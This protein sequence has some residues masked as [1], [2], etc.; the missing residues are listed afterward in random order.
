MNPGGAPRDAF[1][2]STKIVKKWANDKQAWLYQRGPYPTLLVGGQNSG[3]TVGCVLKALTLLQTYPGSR[4]AVIRR[5]NIQLEKTTMESWFQ[6]CSAP[7]YRPYGGFNKNSGVLDFNNGSRVYFLHLDQPDSLDV[8]AGLELN[9]AYVSQVEEI[10]EKA[11]DLLDVRV[12]RWTGATIPEEIIAAYPGGREAWPWR[13]QDDPTILVPPRYI[14]AEG[15]VTDETHWL[16]QRFADESPFREKWKAQGYACKIVESAENQFAIKAVTDSLY[17][18]DEDYLRRYVRP[19]WG[20]PEG[21]IFNVSP[22]S[23]L[24]P[25]PALLDRIRSAMRWHRALDHGDSAPTCCVWYAVD[26]DNNIFVVRE[27]YK[28]NLLVTQHRKAIFELGKNDPPY[29]T[30][31]ADPSIF[32]KSRGRS[33]DR[34]PEWSIA[35]EWRDQRIGDPRTAISW[36]RSQNDEA[37][38]VSR[39]KEFLFVDPN[40]RHPITGEPGAPHIYF[41]VATPEYPNGC[42]EVLKDIRAQRR[43]SV[44]IVG[45]VKVFSDDRDDTVRDHGYDAC[46]APD[47][48]IL[49]GDLRWVPAGDILVGDTLLGFDRQGVRLRPR[50]W[51]PAV[52]EAVRK[53]QAPSYR[54]TFEDGTEITCAF[55]HEWPTVKSGKA[56]SSLSSYI[57]RT[58]ESL[59]RREHGWKANHGAVSHRRIPKAF[60]PWLADDTHGAGYL[61]GIFDGEGCLGA[62]LGFAQ[63]DNVVLSRALAELRT[64]GFDLGVY[65]VHGEAI[66]RVAINGGLPERLRLLGS[67]RPQRLLDKLDLNLGRA[68]ALTAVRI[69][70]AVSVGLHDVVAIQTTTGTYVV[71]GLLSSNCKYGLV[72]RPSP[73]SPGGPP[74]TPPGQIAIATYMEAGRETRLRR[75]RAARAAG[76]GIKYGF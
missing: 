2:A 13:P 34:A 39:M 47:A 22:L 14:F 37:T 67:I 53:F 17:A 60:V 35:D 10:S 61:A 24:Q 48:R 28:E 50:Q 76:T 6:W 9:F 31:Y 30:N 43:K 29:Q 66:V 54:L 12:G 18:K 1:V 68:Q 33:A 11:W 70:D 41:I 75:A 7:F 69:V 20:N 55:N 32:G 38:T 59:L 64:R 51:R 56:N 65:R 44:A 57:W 26:A 49:R 40:H 36:L 58:T 23:L 19:R 63:N 3:K 4:I 25:T 46:V 21:A 72:M 45:D 5:S 42:Y 74:P 16:F 15:Y 8:L 52:V 71:E 73:A 62:Q 27:H